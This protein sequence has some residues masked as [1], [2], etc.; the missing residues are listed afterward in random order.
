MKQ[1]WLN[2]KENTDLIV[3]F[4]G[5]GDGNISFKPCC[6]NFDVLMFF[7]YRTFDEIDIDFSHYKNKYLICWSMGVYVCN[8]YYDKFN[9]FNKLIAI[10]GTQKPIDDNFGI[11]KFIYD[12]TIQ[13]FNELSCNKFVKKMSPSLAPDEYATHS[14]EELKN[15][16]ISIK[17]LEIK[18][19]LKF[20]KAIISLKDKIFPP[21]NQMNWWKTQNV[22]MEISENSFHYIFDIYKKWSDLI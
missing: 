2:K 20:D 17:N 3:F 13:N 10:N 21:Q 6:E 7:D 11:P 15:E 22:K 8:Y 1:E 16:L 19:L 12:L 18:E 9:N 4:S 5:W 14:I